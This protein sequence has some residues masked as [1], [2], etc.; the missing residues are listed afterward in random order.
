MLTPGER[1]LLNP[2]NAWLCGFT[3]LDGRMRFLT[4]LKLP[5]G[6]DLYYIIEL[7]L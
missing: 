6:P 7:S 4:G 3:T 5:N 1:P 2:K